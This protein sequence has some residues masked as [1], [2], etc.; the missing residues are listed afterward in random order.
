VIFQIKCDTIVLLTTVES[1]TP[2]WSTQRYQ[3]RPLEF[4]T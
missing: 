2:V 3:I 1:C 4:C